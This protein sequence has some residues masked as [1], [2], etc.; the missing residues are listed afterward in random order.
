MKAKETAAGPH[1]QNPRSILMFHPAHR[2]TL[3]A[4]RQNA[5]RFADSAE[6]RDRHIN[7]FGSDV[8]NR[9]K[10]YAEKA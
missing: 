10:R 2:P 5:R 3:S 1:R 8:F 9:Q 4:P 6:V 7:P